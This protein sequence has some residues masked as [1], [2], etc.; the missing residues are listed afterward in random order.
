MDT[1]ALR[2]WWKRANGHAGLLGGTAVAASVALGAGCSADI[3]DESPP[4]E[5]PLAERTPPRASY[6]SPIALSRDD[7]LLWVVNSDTDRVSVIRTDTNTVLG[8]LPVGDGPQSIAID[9]ANRYAY[10]ANAQSNDVSVI[11]IGQLRPNGFAAGARDR[12]ITTGGAPSSVVV[13]PDGRRVF[14]ANGSQ[15]T[16]TVLD[17]RD[18]HF[19]GL[20][21]LRKGACNGDD[22]SRHFQP[23]AMA[24][25]ADGRRLYVTRFLSYTRPGGVQADDYGKEG[26]VCRIDLD[27]GSSGLRTRLTPIRLAPSDTGFADT[28]GGATGAFPN[29]LQ[30]IVLRDGHAYLPNI[31]ASPTG[32]LHFDVDTQAYVNRIDGIG[33]AETDGG[34]LN[35]HLGARDP[36]PGKPMLF[37]AN[38]SAMAFTT[39]SGRGSAYVVS[40]ASDLLVK[41]DVDAAGVLHF[42]TDDNTTRYIDLNDP[43][44]PETRGPNAGKNPMGIVINARGTK[45]YVVNHVSRNV[46][47]VNLSS[48]RVEAVVSTDRLPLP[49][50]RD[51]L[52]LVGAEMFFSSR[53]NFVRPDGA[54]GSNRNRLS[55]HGH[56]ACSSCHPAG[57]TDGVVWQFASG[58]RK[59][60]AINGT[61]NPRN[62]AQQRIINASA[63]FD[64]LEDVDFNTRRVSS[65]E[66]LTTPRPC[67]DSMPPSGITQSTNDPDHGLI[68]GQENDFA[69]APCVLV[70]FAA[71]N[72]NRPQLRVQLPGSSTLVKATDALREWQRSAVVTPNRAMTTSELSA[73]GL[74]GAGDDADRADRGRELFERAGCAT[75]HGGG[76]WTMKQKD[77]VSPPAPGEIATEAAA[78]GANAMQYMH[79]FLTDVGTFDLN[80]PGSD[81]PLPGYPAIGGIERDTNG[82]KALGFD[83]D[84]DGK[85]NGYNTPSL[86]GSYSVPPY[87]HNGACETFQCVLTHVKHRRAGQQ[88][89]RPDPLDSDGARAS[90]ALYLESID[91]RTRPH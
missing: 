37:F 16:I 5:L 41:L 14:V 27:A 91:V 15:D 79:R 2:V 20:I 30:S 72:E 71:A 29:Q 9:P 22:P 64:E 69:M 28:R 45:A 88:P 17:G 47:V 11:D 44:A 3:S 60:I 1:K 32:P 53:G 46:S 68:L 67:V 57:L 18:Q 26:L 31:A 24:I 84:G 10:V 25:A 75:C 13:S 87:F 77:F 70:P 4:D 33:G 74:T 7:S 66:P 59:T 80:V 49:G 56:Q 90:L 6:S 23:R 42:T 76:Q 50:S 40:S 54:G 61:T 86:L 12:R 63:I 52:L 19:V 34:A 21:D 73:A 78:P 8:G 36:E 83:Y 38:P 58:P 89:G 81:N 39:Q 62:R 51:E 85:G 82:L 35:L 43:D 55:D 65:G 48:D